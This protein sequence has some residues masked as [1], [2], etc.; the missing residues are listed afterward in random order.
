[1]GID[2][3]LALGGLVIPPVF[4]FIKKPYVVPAWPNNYVRMSGPNGGIEKGKDGYCL[5]GYF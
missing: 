3:L 1:M 4:D 2:A 5:V